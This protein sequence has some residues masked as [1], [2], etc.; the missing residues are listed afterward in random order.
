M[1]VAPTR[2]H[3]S[4]PRR[5]WACPRSF[6]VVPGLLLVDYCMGLDVVGPELLCES[7]LRA[8]RERERDGALD[9]R[10]CVWGVRVLDRIGEVGL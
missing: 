1:D 3:R 6:E 7:C 10:E 8:L 9:V 2:A 4:T 5:W